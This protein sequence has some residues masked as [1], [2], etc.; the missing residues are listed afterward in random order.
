MTTEYRYFKYNTPEYRDRYPVD[1]GTGHRWSDDQ[2]DWMQVGTTIAYALREV[3]KGRAVET[4]ATGT[5]IAEGEH[6]EV[7]VWSTW[8]VE[9]DQPEPGAG[10]AGEKKWAF[11]WTEEQHRDFAAKASE[12]EAGCVITAGSGDLPAPAPGLTPRTDKAEYEVRL[13][14]HRR[15]V[16]R[17]ELSRTLERELAEARVEVERLKQ[18]LAT[19]D[20][21]LGQSGFAKAGDLRS[22]ISKSIG[23][24]LK[25][26]AACC[27]SSDPAVCD[28]VNKNHILVRMS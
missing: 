8:P 6:P 21:K 13:G 10:G 12:M 15:M 11:G 27:N 7:N 19:V 14:K 1:G 17:P 3:A 24:D 25:P 9:S 5:A 28:C 26:Y 2:F 23:G 4:T 18:T 20:E 16:V 22:L